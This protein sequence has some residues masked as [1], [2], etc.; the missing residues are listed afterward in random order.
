[1]L[2]IL[3]GWLGLSA[4]HLPCCI[5]DFWGIPKWLM[6]NSPHVYHGSAQHKWHSHPSHV[7]EIGMFK[8]RT[9]NCQTGETQPWDSPWGDGGDGG[10]GSHKYRASPSGCQ[11]VT[12]TRRYLVLDDVLA[13]SNL[14]NVLKS[15]L[16]VQAACEDYLPSASHNGETKGVHHVQTL[17]NPCSEYVFKYGQLS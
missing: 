10:W 5:T 6:L 7:R 8:T 1:M 15:V 17:H 9:T 3:G 12:M 4:K 16:A 2:V 14:S 13:L 11:L